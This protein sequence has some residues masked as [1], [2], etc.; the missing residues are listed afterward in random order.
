MHLLATALEAAHFPLPGDVPPAVVASLPHWLQTV[1]YVLGMVVP[2]ASLVVAFLNAYVRAAKA[3][4][5]KVPTWLLAVGAALNLAALNP[6]KSVEQVK[7]ATK[8]EVAP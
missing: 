7:A 3:R 6:D 1:T 5:E 2:L 4:D 8:P